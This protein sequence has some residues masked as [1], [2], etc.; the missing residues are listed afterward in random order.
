MILNNPKD[1]GRMHSE[2]SSQR[3]QVEVGRELDLEAD[4][5]HAIYHTSSLAD[6]FATRACSP[7]S[8][9]ISIVEIN[10]RPTQ[11]FLF[12]KKIQIQ[13]NMHDPVEDLAACLW[14]S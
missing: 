1:V 11:H 4:I 5:P 2:Q 3:Q 8:Y 6:H 14:M 13:Y 12:G 9:R 7:H 10:G